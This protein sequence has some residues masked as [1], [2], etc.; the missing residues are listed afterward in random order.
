MCIRDRDDYVL[1]VR[2][3]HALQEVVTKFLPVRSRKGGAFLYRCLLYT[4][5]RPACR[6]RSPSFAEKGYFA[7]SIAQIGWEKKR[8]IRRFF[9]LFFGKRGQNFSL[10][11]FLRLV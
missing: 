6:Q 2:Q 3:P 9:Q 4:S 10:A 8:Q 5:G 11:L 7:F 1:V